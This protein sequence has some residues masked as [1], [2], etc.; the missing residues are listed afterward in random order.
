M[1]GQRWKKGIERGMMTGNE[2]K[3]V[4]GE[5]AVH[6]QGEEVKGVLQHEVVLRH[7]VVLQPEEGVIHIS[8]IVQWLE[9]LIQKK[10]N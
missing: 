3:E 4:K 6:Q 8:S 1:E 10:Y 5:K 7:E 2:E 9:L